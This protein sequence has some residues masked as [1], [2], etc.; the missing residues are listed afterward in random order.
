MNREIPMLNLLNSK[1]MKIRR[2]VYT[3][4]FHFLNT[5]QG[6]RNVIVSDLSDD[7]DNETPLFVQ[8]KNYCDLRDIMSRNTLLRLR[9]FETFIDEELD[10]RFFL[11]IVLTPYGALCAKKA[12]NPCVSLGKL[13]LQFF[14]KFGSHPCG[15][16]KSPIDEDNKT[17]WSGGYV[18]EGSTVLKGDESTA[19]EVDG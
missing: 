11:W 16:F 12:I 14:H 19:F 18:D 2:R 4:A 5:R 6:E 13:T 9:G 10:E 15:G 7:I 3:D 8:E 17:D 1:W